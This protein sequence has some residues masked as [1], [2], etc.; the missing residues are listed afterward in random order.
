MK[1]KYDEIYQLI[2]KSNEGK[3]WVAI[4]LN[5]KN[6]K[7]YDVINNEVVYKG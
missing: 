1:L 5:F 2:D 7:Y 3:I 4:P 6:S